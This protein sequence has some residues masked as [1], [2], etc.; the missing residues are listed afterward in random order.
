MKRGIL[1][2]MLVAALLVVTPLAK[3]ATFTTSIGNTSPPFANGSH[4]SGVTANGALTG[5]PAPF[6]AM[7]GNDNTSN[8][9]ANWTFSYAPPAGTIVGGTLTLGIFDIDSHAPGNQVASY[10][11]GGTDLTALLNAASEG[12]NGGNGATNSEYDVLTINLPSTTFAA[13]ESGSVLISLALQGPGLGVLATNP[14]HNGA[15]LVFS[16]LDLQTG[17]RVPEPSSLT[18]LFVAFSAFLI[19]PRKIIRNLQR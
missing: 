13:L 19:V 9:S 5:S 16:T 12:L 17:P 18:L 7:C 8:C 14:A 6:N 15:D 4:P 2:L 10:S 1:A 11:V 3:A